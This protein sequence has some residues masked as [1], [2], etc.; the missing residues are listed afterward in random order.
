MFLLPTRSSGLSAAS[1]RH[2]WRAAAASAVALATA[3]F[4]FA[5]VVPAAAKPGIAPI[6]ERECDS[7][8]TPNWVHMYPLEGARCYGFTG[9]YPLNRDDD[10]WFCPGNNKGH[11][12]LR[13]SRGNFQVPFSP[14]Q[15]LRELPAFLSEVS[16]TITGWSGN[17]KCPAA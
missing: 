7:G 5:P 13:D 14:G 8:Q 3:F 10:I 11:L 4:V 9:T 17:A 6:Q 12:I 1:G 2:Y 15:G 16:I